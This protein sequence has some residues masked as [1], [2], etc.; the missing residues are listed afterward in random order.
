MK[1]VFNRVII[2]RDPHATNVGGVELPPCAVGQGKSHGR[3]RAAFGTL[4]AVHGRYEE[5]AKVG[6]RVIFWELAGS[7][8]IIEGKEVTVMAAEEM[9]A[10]LEES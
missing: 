6:S 1:P 9:I 7:D 4:L 10:T 8:V 5:V 3:P 2:K